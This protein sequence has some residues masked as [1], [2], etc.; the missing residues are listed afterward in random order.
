[1][2]VKDN[3][4]VEAFNRNGVV[5]ARAVVSHR[6]PGG[7]TIMYH[8]QDRHLNVPISEVSGTRGGTENSLTKNFVKPTHMIGGYAQ[9]PYGFNYYGPTGSQ[10]DELTVMRKSETEV[11]Y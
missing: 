7:T 9:L 3:D 2:G 8:S 11:V 4:W 5:S 1:M 10:R 6:I